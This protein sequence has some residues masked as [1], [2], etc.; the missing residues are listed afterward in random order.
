MTVNLKPVLNHLRRAIPSAIRETANSPRRMHGQEKHDSFLV[1]PGLP[2][3]S[4]TLPSDKEAL[5]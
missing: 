3:P 4:L 2:S 1:R 5:F